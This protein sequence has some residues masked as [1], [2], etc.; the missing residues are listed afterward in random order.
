M[1]TISVNFPDQVQVD[2]LEV[3]MLIAGSLYEK[4]RLSAG[5][6]ATVV[7]L[8]KTVFI[9]LLSKYGFSVSQLSIEVIEADVQA[10]R[11]WV[12]S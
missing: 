11:S 9:E 10:L 12:K 8:S 5:Q 4:G 2:D 7:G 1:R 3:K 6:A